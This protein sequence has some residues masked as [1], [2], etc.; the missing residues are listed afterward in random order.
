MP[1]DIVVNYFAGSP[2]ENK[3]ERTFIEEQGVK[4]HDIRIGLQ[5]PEFQG[6]MTRK[7]FDIPENAFCIS[8]VGNRLP[9]ECSDFFYI[10]LHVS[11]KQNRISMLHLSDRRKLNLKKK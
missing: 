4:V 9:G 5:Y 10:R 7:D 3:V 2:V 11:G 6:E 1:A 8:L